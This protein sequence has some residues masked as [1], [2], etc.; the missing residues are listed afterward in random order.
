MKRMLGI[1]FIL[2]V[3][4]TISTGTTSAT[5]YEGY[6]PEPMD[7]VESFL[8]SN[9]F[10]EELLSQIDEMEFDGVWAYT[11]IAFESGHTNVTKGRDGGATEFTFS[12]ADQSNWGEC[13]HVDF[14]SG[15]Q[16]YFKVLNH[17]IIKALSPYNFNNKYLWKNQLKLFEL[18]VSSETLDYFGDDFILP[19]ETIIAGFDDHY[20]WWGDMD[21]DDLIVA[22]FRDTDRDCVQNEIDNC[23]VAY[24]PDQTDPDGDAIG[25][26]CDNCPDVPN[27]E[28][29]DTEMGCGYTPAE[30]FSIGVGTPIVDG[31]MDENFDGIIDKNF[32]EWADAASFDFDL[33]LPDCGSIPATFL[34]M[35]DSANLHWAV[36]VESDCI[37]YIKVAQLGITLNGGVA[38]IGSGLLEESFG[39]VYEASLPL[40]AIDPIPGCGDAV[41]IDLQLKVVKQGTEALTDL[42]V[43][44]YLG[45]QISPA[46][47]GVGDACDN[48]QHDYNPDQHDTD[49]DIVG[50]VCDNCPDVA[51]SDQADYDGD[52]WIVNLDGTKTLCVRDDCGGDECDSDDDNDGLPDW[53]E[54][55]FFGSAVSQQGAGDDPD[56]EGLDNLGEYEDYE[57]S[58][59]LEGPDPNDPDTDDDAWND[60]W[61]AQAGTSSIDEASY[62]DGD[63][64]EDGIFVDKT[65]GDDSNLGAKI[66]STI[67]AVRSIHAAVDRLNL[68]EP[69]I[70]TI[71]FLTPGIYSV[72]DPEP[73]LPLVVRQNV[74]FDAAGV[75][76]DGTGAGNWKQGI[77][78]S[79][80][81]NDITIRGLNVF[82][83]KEGIGFST[84]GGCAAFDSV[85]INSC[86]TGIQFIDANQVNTDITNTKIQGCDAGIRFESESSDNTLIF[87][88]SQSGNNEIVGNHIGVDVSGGTGNRLINPD[89]MNG[90]YG[91]KLSSDG[92]GLIVEDADLY[93]LT[94]GIGFQT[95]AGKVDVFRSKIRDSGI[96]VD[97]LENRMIHVNLGAGDD[98]SQI[99][100]CFDS[101]I[102]FR[103]GSANNTV[104]YGKVINNYNDGIRFEA[105]GETPDDNLIYGTFVMGNAHA[106]I[107]VM[108]G[109]DNRFEYNTV[110]NNQIGFWLADGSA[111]NLIEY[112]A[113]DANITNFIL[114]GQHNLIGGYDENGLVDPD[115]APYVNDAGGLGFLSGN[116]NQLVGITLDGT[117]IV[118]KH[119]LLVSE[120]AS[121]LVL[122]GLRISN[123]MVGV[124][125]EADGACVK[126]KDVDIFQ[127]SIGMDITEKYLLDIDLEGS[128][129]YNCEVGIR[130]NA[131]SSN[132]TVRNG[133]IQLN[134]Q[135][136]ILVDGCA[137]TP[138][139]NRFVDMIIQ[140]NGAHG[141]AFLG[142]FGNKLEGSTIK[143]NNLGAQ[144]DAFAGVAVLNGSASITRC[145]IFDNGCGGVFAD[146]AA[147]T[148]IHSNLI[149]NNPEGIRLSFVDQVTIASNTITANGAGL[150]IE[151]G[152]LPLVSYN[153]LH[154]N[155]SDP[156][157]P[158]DVC[159]EGDFNPL[160]LIENNIGT[161][162]Q[163]DLPPSNISVDPGFADAANQDYSLAPTSFCIDASTYEEPGLDIDDLSRPKGFSWDLGAFETSGFKDLDD[164]GM[165]DDWEDAIVGIPGGYINFSPDGH[166]DDDGITNLEE[167]L[168]G[169]DPTVSVYV[170]INEPDQSPSFVNTTTVTLSGISANA[171]TIVFS[172]GSVLNQ[173][174]DIQ[175]YGY[176]HSNGDWWLNSFQLHAI[177]NY[178]IVQVTAVGAGDYAG[179]SETR[180]L[181]IIRDQVVPEISIINPT[182]QG[183]YTTTL[184]VIFISGIASDDTQLDDIA[185]TRT[186]TV[187]CPDPIDPEGPSVPMIIQ[188]TAVGLE[189]W[190]TGDIVLCPGTNTIEISAYD[191]FGNLNV[192]LIEVVQNAA[193]T[194]VTSTQDDQSGDGAQQAIVDPL[195]ADGDYF[196]NDDEIACGADA[197]D[198]ASVPEIYSLAN[199]YLTGEKAGYYI[200]DCLNPDVDNDQLPNWWEEQYFSESS[201][202]AD[203]G[204]DDDG[205]GIYNIDE[206]QNGTHPLVPQTVAFTLTMI[207]PDTGLPEDTDWLPQ[208]GDSVIIEATW[209]TDHGIAP[210]T[211]VFSLRSA[212]NHPG[213]AVNDPN[214]S[215][216]T[217]HQYPAW[218]VDNFNGPDFGITQNQ[219]NDWSECTQTCFSQGTLTA[220]NQGDGTYIIYLHSFDF[221]GSVKVLVT[222]PVSGNYLGQLWVP[223][224][225]NKNG[226][227]SGWDMD[228]IVI[229]PNSIDPADLDPN[230]DTDA[231]IFNNPGFSS[232]LGDDFS[233]FEEYRGIV[234]T[235]DGG[236]DLQHK[237][238]DPDRKDLFV[239][240]QGFYDPSDP[241]GPGPEY[242]FDIDTAFQNAGIT[243]HNTTGWGHDATSDGSIYQY[244]GGGSITAISKD[245]LQRSVVIGSGTQWSVA[246]PTHEWELNLEGSGDEWIPIRSWDA[247]NRLVLDFDSPI[248]GDILNLDYAIRKPLPHMNILLVRHDRSGTYSGQDGHLR[249]VSASPPSQQNPLGTRYWRWSTKGYARCQSTINQASMYGMAVTLEIPLD[250]YF[251]DMPYDDG[252]EWNASTLTWENL[253][254]FLNPL[255]LVEDQTDL[256]DPVDGILLGDSANGVWDG[257]KRRNDFNG[258]LNPFDIN[259]N[260][261]VELPVA[262]DPTVDLSR[263]EYTINQVL[264]HTITHEIAH[265][266]AGPFHTNDPLCLMYRYSNNW[267]RA[268]YL[269]DYYRSLIRIHN[270]TR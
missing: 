139:E 90:D 149:Y 32:G 54:L 21:F 10:N 70:Y 198:Y 27:D 24:N 116:G 167:F 86:Q 210:A 80:M 234:Y 191:I 36:S 245:N 144:T 35:N 5:Y 125:F 153:I 229:T 134:T 193:E 104:L 194:G 233:N 119:G 252:L 247:A 22:M 100:G 251:N 217:N 158:Y 60:K 87:W 109:S 142:G 17:S 106:G 239:R 84:G 3:A 6:F 253:D 31:I 260:G 170:A 143:N 216:L 111:G 269:S 157:C 221:G 179:Q 204:A 151:D 61:E 164:D 13:R 196:T 19:P 103:A 94:V 69:G 99:T 107:A 128:Q 8:L 58:G 50:D 67:Y 166:A 172:D 136:G 79:F 85:A 123:F 82:G 231:I 187:T 4:M 244:F 169:T 174:D 232:P 201:T 47:D 131:G 250:S 220:Q 132:N 117:G 52:A 29:M 213:R 235:L 11:A 76:I 30:G 255:N 127:C 199:I 214:P 263:D 228:G 1:L 33:K 108:D 133:L 48:C 266:L 65:N 261:M 203:P 137:E 73:D 190:I 68:L 113:V 257:D 15:G 34:V 223:E 182:N 95:D 225:S 270:I 124:A 209:D 64:F 44:G 74:I 238:L 246:W 181:T 97:F 115:K 192:A 161:V 138:D 188:G 37:E 66:G 96:G 122:D 59:N 92:S 71:K 267:N 224:G 12:T 152:A 218:Y 140:N 236:T 9:Y 226:I 248:F 178:N 173:G 130:L 46:G 155:N 16:L 51:N 212:S 243:I 258:D 121:N 185:W 72:G 62:P 91:I 126:L 264:V 163:I 184:P 168:Q 40:A 25:D 262:S 183:S 197:Y 101:G 208:F 154:G 53:W 18:T 39:N 55:T 93:N 2:I 120:G 200:P 249:F 177:D 77:L 141:V 189:S 56:G 41:E 110:A 23:A 98:A 26:A 256:M 78:F 156:D 45:F 7:T 49:Q 146:E 14:D 240:A 148:Q 237:R 89:I 112:G 88:D 230:A 159:L 147:G 219:L 186:A 207:D 28:Q 165:P 42:P 43:V 118:R 254:V 211:A 259:S 20:W 105:C 268:H 175:D 215:E 114:E 75:T 195:D 202:D 206:F 242:T 63:I 81:A 162:N 241:T 38:T 145:R 135:D 205:D 180:S 129:I 222:D 227:G 57:S 102:L 171:S 160:N 83:F 265:A 176:L 150:V